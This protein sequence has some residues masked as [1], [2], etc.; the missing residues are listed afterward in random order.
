MTE[1]CL[2][3]DVWAPANAVD[4]AQGK[5][6]TDTPGL[7]VLVWIHGGA[8]LNGSK[9]DA[10]SGEA[11]AQRGVIFVGIN[12]RVGALGF[13]KPLGGDAN[14]GLWDQ[15]QALRWVQKE[16]AAFGGDPKQVTIMGQSAGAC[17]VFWL[18]S[19]A[20]ANQHFARAI[21]M[22]PSSFTV[23]PEQAKE[24]AEEFATVVGARSAT[25]EDMQELKLEA[26]LTA[27][28]EGKF[29]IHPTT[30]PGWRELSANMHLPEVPPHA[31]P[32]PAGLFRWPVCHEPGGWP[33][34]VA[35]VDGEVLQE[36]PLTALGRGVAKHL[37]IIVGGTRDENGFLPA[38]AEA[39]NHPADGSFGRFVEAGE[40]KEK[41]LRRFAWEIAGAPM[42]KKLSPEELDSLIAELL[43]A[44]EEELESL[45][46]TAN[47][48]G[49][50][51]D[52]D[53]CREQHIQ[54]RI[55]SDF[56]FL[57]KVQMISDRLSKEGNSGKFYRYQFD[58]FRAAGR[59]FHGKELEFTLSSDAEVA[60]WQNPCRTERQ[61]VRRKWLDSWAAFVKTGDPNTPEMANSW[62]E[63]RS[64]AGSAAKPTMHWDGIYGF[65]IES[66]AV[67]CARAGLQASVRLYEKLWPSR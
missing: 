13:L 43:P 54:N 11:Y 23:T 62:R 63:H 24:L 58:G 52:P 40:P 3:L 12:Y 2:L 18:I 14:C 33:M 53:L 64:A 7:P 5:K 1:D 39:K 26:V 60:P 48:C 47:V 46:T 34:P 4:A 35:V 31:D 38:S 50:G 66:G 25:L 67:A 21:L 9:D 45:G 56:S 20:L 8:L 49:P 51:E 41:M 42:S 44:Y 65:Q 37:D 30:G 57:A 22:S 15:V 32:T 59:A 16:I 28:F 55:A 61:E 17:S 36:D 27:Q 6:S 19:S 29:R 10:S